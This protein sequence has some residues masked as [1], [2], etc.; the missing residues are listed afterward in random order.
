VSHWGSPSS[1]RHTSPVEFD[2]DKSTLPIYKDM[3]Q[4]RPLHEA[5]PSLAA[6][7]TGAGIQPDCLMTT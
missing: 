7:S 4:S 6:N 2:G 5:Q 3:N 1:V